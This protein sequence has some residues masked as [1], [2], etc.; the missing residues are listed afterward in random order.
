MT[1]R[2]ADRQ[3]AFVNVFVTACAVLH[4]AAKATRALGQK[5][6][7][8]VLVAFG[9]GELGVLPLHRE[10]DAFM[11]KEARIFDSCQ[12]KALPVDDRK[13][14]SVVVAVTDRTIVGE[15]ALDHTVKA[16]T[17]IDLRLNDVV[18]LQARRTHVARPSSVTVAARVLRIQ[19][20]NAGMDSRQF[21]RRLLPYVDESDGKDG[22]AGANADPQMRAFPVHRSPPGSEALKKDPYCSA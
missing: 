9:A 19:L 3:R 1:L 18:A 12:A 2:A 21:T 16:G 4:E 11:I 6:C 20:G 22:D 14:C 15:R 13:A 8:C 10:A 5:F 17:A 7:L